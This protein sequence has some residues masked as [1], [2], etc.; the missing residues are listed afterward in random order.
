MRSEGLPLLYTHTVLRK[1]H[2]A[3]RGIAPWQLDEL[4]RS[5]GILG[6]VPS[7]D[8]LEGTV[9]AFPSCDQSLGWLATQYQEF[10]AV[11]GN[12]HVSFGSDI[13]GALDHIAPGCGS[14]GLW[15]I[16]QYPELWASLTRLGAPTPKPLSAMIDGFLETWER[17]T[18]R[19]KIAERH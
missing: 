1:Y 2:G 10:V 19:L 12:T 6:V 14:E 9:S 7:E 3:E 8:Y 4:R 17:V 15:N 5:Q 11:L 16:S 18:S 13:N